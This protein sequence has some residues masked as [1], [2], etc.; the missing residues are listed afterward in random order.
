VCRGQC[1]VVQ[2]ISFMKWLRKEKGMAQ[3]R[4]GF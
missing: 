1:L 3:T 4:S 2:H